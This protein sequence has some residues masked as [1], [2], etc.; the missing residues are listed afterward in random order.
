M[1]YF[2]FPVIYYLKFP[3]HASFSLRKTMATKYNGS[4]LLSSSTIFSYSYKKEHCSISISCKNIVGDSCNDT[5]T[6]NV[7]KCNLIK[8][9]L[10][11]YILPLHSSPELS[12]GQKM[13]WITFV[14]AV[15]KY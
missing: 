3:T 4:F 2:Y 11:L 15:S 14:Y 10:T 7:I 9:S 12:R 8:L 5:M 1:L 13:I 6:N